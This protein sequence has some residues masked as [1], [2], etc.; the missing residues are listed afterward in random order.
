[1]AGLNKEVVALTIMKLN[2]QQIVAAHQSQPG[3]LT[4]QISDDVKFQVV[5]VAVGSLVFLSIQNMLSL[6]SLA[7]YQK[8]L[9]AQCH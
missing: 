4:K 5:S 6:F 3:A 1:M 2:Y 9:L 7:D 8:C